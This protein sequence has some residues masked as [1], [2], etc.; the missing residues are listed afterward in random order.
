MA[1]LFKAMGLLALGVAA[2]TNVEPVVV[3]GATGPTGAETYNLLKSRGVPVRA[4]VR[5]T[6]KA[7]D[8]LGCSKCDESEGIFVGD[9]TKP[10]TLAS[11][12]KG[13]AALV[14]VTSSSPQCTFGAGPPKCTYPMGA[15]PVDIDFNGGKNQ[16]E[17]FAKEAGSKPVILVSAAG[18]TEPDSFLDK[19]GN[20][21]I[22]FYKLNFEAFLMTSGLPFTIVKP[23]GLGTGKPFGQEIVVGHDDTEAWDLKI[24]IQRS[25][26]A[27]VLAEILK[28]PKESDGVRFDLCARDPKLGKATT[29][30]DLPALL[31]SAKYPWMSSSA[32][33]QV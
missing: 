2:D 28:S 27:R 24:P 4:L 19:M 5:N 31:K 18:T 20:G 11:V 9:V 17:V 13:A 32:T 14:I 6:T 25:D 30:A 10:D 16:V 21:Y 15:Y 7:R 22:S 33:V 8:T 3:T 29:D 26:V 23:C 12:M 1:V